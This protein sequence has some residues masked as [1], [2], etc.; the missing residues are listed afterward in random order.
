MPAPAPLAARPVPEAAD[1][2][3]EVLENLDR[4]EAAREDY[5]ATKTDLQEELDG[6]GKVRKTTERTFHVFYLSG[7]RVQKLVSENGQPLSA[8]RALAE[9]QR[10]AKI[11]R[12]NEARRAKK[13]RQPENAREGEND[14]DDEPTAS[15]ILRLCRFVNG[16][17]EMFR[18]LEVLVYDFEPRPDVKTRGL[19]ESWIT[20]LSGRVRIDEAA[21]QLVRLEAQTNDSLKVAGGLFVTIK[22]GSTLAFEQEHVRGEIWLPSL[23]EVSLSA[24]FLLFKGIRTH[25]VS[26]F[27]D[28]R[29]FAVDTKSEIKG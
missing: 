14:D 17:R 4:V 15:R 8:A 6:S 25:Q 16:R 28:Y 1:I 27:T 23:G 12:E 19:V 24:R 22:K 18:G 11:L 2:L 20:K 26:R 29:K 9:D 5:T 13:G 3:R 7:L 10:I 21:R